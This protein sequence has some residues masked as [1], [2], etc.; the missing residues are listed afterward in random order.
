MLQNIVGC[1]FRG[2]LDG[3]KDIAR[4]NGPQGVCVLLDGSILVA[5][6]GNHRIRMVIV[7]IVLLLFCFFVF[8]CLIFKY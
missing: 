6:T 5:D 2:Y 1:G 8:F 3:P 7:I 4:F